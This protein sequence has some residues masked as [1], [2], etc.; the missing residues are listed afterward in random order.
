MRR[1][2]AS[3]LCFAGR[4]GLALSPP[5]PFFDY[6]CVSVIDP[7]TDWDEIHRFATAEVRSAEVQGFLPKPPPRTGRL[8]VHHASDILQECP[9]ATLYIAI[10]HFYSTLAQH[11]DAGGRQDMLR[12]TQELARAASGSFPTHTICSSRWPVFEILAL[13]SGALA[14]DLE[15]ACDDLQTE[16]VDWSQLRKLASQWTDLWGMTSLF[17][18]PDSLEHQTD[19]VKLEV[20]TLNLALLKRANEAREQCP[21]GTLWVFITQLLSAATRTTQHFTAFSEAVDEDLHS[22]SGGGGLLA[23]PASGWPIFH[24]L[25][26]VADVNKGKRYV[27][28]DMKYLRRFG[29]LDL[30][31]EELAPMAGEAPQPGDTQSDVFQAWRERFADSAAIFGSMPWRNFACSLKKRAS[32]S[33]RPI[34]RRMLSAI[35]AV[36]GTRQGYRRIPSSRA[37]RQVASRKRRRSPALRGRHARRRAVG[38]LLLYGERWS[39]FLP[40]MVRHLEQLG[41][42]WP[43]LI[44]SIGDAAASACEALR[45]QRAASRRDGV[46]IRVACWQPNTE[47]QVHRFTITH[48]L[49][50]LG[51]DVFYFDMDTFFFRDPLPAVLAQAAQSRLEALFASHADGD[52]INIGLFYM[53]ATR[54]SAAWFS[55]FLQW[56]HDH[57]YEIDQRGLDVFLGSPRRQPFSDLGISYP[58]QRLPIRAGALEDSN[59]VVIGFIGWAGDIGQMLVFHWCNLP[60]ERKW[61]ELLIVYDAA[62]A[63]QEF[64]P[65]HIAIA[66][67]SA[68]SGRRDGPWAR[69]HKAQIVFQA[70]RLPVPPQRTQ[71]LKCW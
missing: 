2:A 25:A 21:F 56:Y 14:K 40:R 15:F 16:L 4:A 19:L 29:D 32:S 30:L 24:A 53:H 57:Q 46:H 39:A 8:I 26:W 9:L 44:V 61:E 3:G 67:Q 35:L 27:G 17:E 58:P 69:V 59:Q 55:V 50:H 42:A 52:C 48:V 41:F 6:D 31:P 47:S 71:E 54:R 37:C 22:L 33:K 68:L 12:L 13:A 23:V 1:A 62:E 18:V 28:R 5:G 20:S 36:A 49:L 38:L 60:L 63:I 66:V 45:R 70:Y 64:V 10:S 51:I 65:F 34:M 11:E 7:I 43:L